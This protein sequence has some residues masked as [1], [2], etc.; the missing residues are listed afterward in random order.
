MPV[1]ELTFWIAFLQIV[2]IDLVLSGDNAVV[3]ALACREVPREW[4]RFA[5]ILGAGAAVALRV[6]LAVL[7][8]E[9]L[10]QPYVKLGGGLLLLWVAARVGRPPPRR[11]DDDGAA[12]PPP[13]SLWTAVRTILIADAVMSLDNVVAIAGAAR[14]S[15]LLLVTGIGVSIPLVI[16]GSRLMLRLIERFPVVVQA[17]AG[18][19][20]WVAGDMIASEPA[21]RPWLAAHLPAA[22]LLLPLAGIATAL[23]GGR[24]LAKSQRTPRG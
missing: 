9:V 12:G 20:G 18:F 15:I 19:I 5:I 23:L 8:F 7:V 13:A 22:P 21:L 10:L 24:W 16:F 11:R 6:V 14:G 2:W 1:T 17:G 3:I 4:Q